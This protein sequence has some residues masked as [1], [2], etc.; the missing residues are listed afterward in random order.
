MEV[1]KDRDRKAAV[2]RT[3]E[4][5]WQLQDDKGQWEDGGEKQNSQLGSADH[6]CGASGHGFVVA[7]SAHLFD[8]FFFFQQDSATLPYLEKVDKID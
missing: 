4:M 1:K 6:T 8:F 3:R 2:S 5:G 7:P